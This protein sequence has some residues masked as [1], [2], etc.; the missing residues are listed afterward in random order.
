MRLDIKRIKAA[1]RNIDPVFLNSPAICLR[2]SQPRARL[3]DRT[4][5]SKR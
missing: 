1:V 4:E 3:P 2:R 5:K